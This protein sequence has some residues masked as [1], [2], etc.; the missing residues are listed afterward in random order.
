MKLTKYSLSDNHDKKAQAQSNK[1][2]KI[3]TTDNINHDKKVNNDYSY[4]YSTKSGHKYISKETLASPD[5]IT[6]KF[7]Q[8][9]TKDDLSFKR[10]G[11]DLEIKI[12][13]PELGRLTLLGFYL[14]PD[15]KTKF[16]PIE[17]KDYT[18][19]FSDLQSAMVADKSPNWL[20]HAHPAKQNND[21]NG[22]NIY[23]YDAGEG[24]RYIPEEAISS[25]VPLIVNFGKEFVQDDLS[26]ERNKDNLNINIKGSA[27]GCLTL[28]NFY[29]S[30]I[31]KSFFKQIKVGENTL[32]LS[33]LKSAMEAD[34]QPK[35]TSN[36]LTTK[37]YYHYYVYTYKP[38]S[39]YKYLPTDALTADLPISLTFA[40]GIKKKDLSFK[41]KDADLEI[42]IAGQVPGR[43]TL[44]NYFTAINNK[45]L[46]LNEFTIEE[47]SLSLLDIQNVMKLNQQPLEMSSSDFFKYI[48]IN[49]KGIYTYHT[50]DGHKY[51]SSH[52]NRYSVSQTIS[53]GHNITKEDL[54]FKLNEKNLEISIKGKVSDKLT[55]F[56]F[57][58]KNNDS[59]LKKIIVGEDILPFADLM[60]AILADKP[61]EWS[62]NA[63]LLPEKSDYRAVCL[64]QAGDGDRYI[65]YGALSSSDYLGLT[66]GEG[67]READ[68]S[69]K[70]DNDNLQIN[71]GGKDPGS[72]TLRGFY[73]LKFISLLSKRIKLAK[74]YLNTFDLLDIK[75][76]LQTDQQQLSSLDFI[77]YPPIKDTGI[78]TYNA[79]DGHKYLVSS[80]I[81]SS[82]PLNLIFGKDIN[83]DDLN[84]KLE[85]Q[86]LEI[87]IKGAK[88]GRLTLLRLDQRASLISSKKIQ[89]GRY[90]L[91][92]TDLLQTM[93][94]NK[95]PEWSYN[96]PQAK[97]VKG[98]NIYTYK[99]EDGNRYI[100]K[101]VLSSDTPLTL[102]FGKKIS[103]D[104]LSFK[105]DQA[106][107]QIT[108]KGAISDQLTLLNFYDLN[109][110][111][112][113]K[114]IEVG[115]S[116]LWLSD[117]K[118]SLEM[119][120]QPEWLS[121][122][123]QAEKHN[124]TTIYT[125]KAEDGHQ[126][127]PKEA[128]SSG[129]AFML[130]FGQG[131]NKNDLSFKREG[132]NLE[133]HI[134]G[135]K[136][137]SLTLFNFYKSSD[138]NLALK[139]LKVEDYTLKFLDLKGATINNKYP[140]LLSSFDLIPYEIINY[141]KIY[142]Y[143]AGDGDKYLSTD[144]LSSLY[145]LSLKLGQGINKN[146]IRFERDESNLKINIA[147]PN[148]SILTL[149]N[150]YSANQATL[151]KEINIEGYSLRFSD[152]KSDTLATIQPTW[153]PKLSA[154]INSTPQA[155]QTT[156]S[157]AAISGNNKENTDQLVNLVA[158]SPNKNKLDYVSQI[159]EKLRS[160]SLDTVSCYPSAKN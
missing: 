129:N 13:R 113:T 33:V 135:I 67:I 50:G 10:N 22:Y 11:T 96:Q 131:V 18:L 28:L 79:G 110:I 60:S 128:I 40:E 89:V 43:L 155:I 145:P 9:I 15:M 136:P 52:L 75:A 125:Y 126:Y 102:T 76:A 68:L 81:N 112:L 4:C 147:G 133:I 77:K 14:L 78:Y 109:S 55:L 8:L 57:N 127:L 149:L 46:A 48:N 61:P 143:N 139:E 114:K 30:T 150:F 58:T 63:I 47:D 93:Q 158:M 144:V 64:Y 122:I 142:T 54:S 94:E 42:N 62:S 83:K 100:P 74:N 7:D 157:N 29:H 101:T 134:A 103:K 108:L 116:T 85:E 6:I 51:I 111:D 56:D 45:N 39:G 25:S 107:L 49:D 132:S 90:I 141:D 35:W 37:K 19:A 53:F 92:F 86:N 146:N 118:S 123:L 71:I 98:I 119:G 138:S 156:E 69:F 27:L 5:S 26:F 104:D 59:F 20:Y 99:A 117:L 154:E 130:K 12:K 73:H 82:V 38:N 72:L 87:N 21:K 97:K 2:N 148:P 80:V 66:F 17:V 120:K 70:R 124:K 95:Q 91:P 105:R 121:N 153:S 160:C 36:I 44:A 32:Q 34:K 41:R 31:K 106:D 140:L 88:P 137:G 84:F 159:K 152:L 23:H 65:P 1:K 151:S 24:H 16:K 3:I 115:K